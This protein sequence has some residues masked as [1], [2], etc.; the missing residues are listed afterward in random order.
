MQ[1]I[2]LLQQSSLTQTPTSQGVYKSVSRDVRPDYTCYYMFGNTGENAGR[3]V[4]V[5]I[6]AK[7]TTNSMH[8]NVVP[9]VSL[10]VGLFLSVVTCYC[11]L[12]LTWLL[13]HSIKAIGYYVTLRSTSQHK[14]PIAIIITEIGVQILLFPFRKCVGIVGVLV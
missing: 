2:G 3:A 14:P 9:Q 1:C 11:V 10:F 4:A 13:T 12:A 6:E 8:K 7:L 5:V